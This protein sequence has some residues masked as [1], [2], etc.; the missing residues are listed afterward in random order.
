MNIFGG[1]KQRSTPRYKRSVNYMLGAIAG[2]IIGSVYEKDNIKTTEFTL[3]GPDSRF[4][5][6]T[7]L[8]VAIADSILHDKDYE[9]ALRDWALQFPFAG[10]GRRFK[11]WLVGII[12]GPYNSWGNGSAM[13]VSPIGYACNS[14]E[15]VLAEAK[16]SAAVTHNHPE[17]I[18]G[19]QAMAAAVFLARIGYSRN[20]IKAHIERTFRYDL[21]RRLDDIRPIYEFDVSCQGS[22]PEA[23]IA[24]LESENFEDAIRKAISIGGDSDTIAS[25]TGAIA[26]AFYREI[27]EAIV[28]KVEHLLPEKMWTVVH[29]FSENHEIRVR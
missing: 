23:M 17:G 13:R 18:K 20:A 9:V 22:V 7:V 10:Y 16:R 26:E 28:R 29:T 24:F 6:D 2:D 8:T 1:A 21:S 14:L 4:T 12:S 25:M 27:P 15:A 5:D 19:A 3:F 11:K